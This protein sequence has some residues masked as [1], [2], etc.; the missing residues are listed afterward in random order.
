M[1]LIAIR[2]SGLAPDLVSIATEPSPWNDWV[3]WPEW[4][5][6][7]QIEIEPS[8]NV[9]RLDLRFL[10]GLVVMVAGT[11]STMVR[12]IVAACLA[13]GAKR[14][15]SFEHHQFPPP[16]EAITHTTTAHDS[17]ESTDGRLPA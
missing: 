17:M 16:G 15:L 8:D 12:R 14:V 1:P 11:D 5:D 9:S 4:T 10:V 13:S 7:P 3:N 6:V 2:R